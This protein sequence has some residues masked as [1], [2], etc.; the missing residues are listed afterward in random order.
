MAEIE[1]HWIN[2]CSSQELKHDGAID[3][4]E[5]SQIEEQNLPTK[6]D[7]KFN[8]VVFFFPKAVNNRIIQIH[9]ML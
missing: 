1:G 2:I 8:N 3:G 4:K 6:G 5:V 9:N 7:C